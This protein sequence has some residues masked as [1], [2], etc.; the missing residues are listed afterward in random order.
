MVILVIASVEDVRKKEIAVWEIASCGVVS[1]AACISG[2]LHN[3]A[4]ALGIF[5]SLLPGIAILFIALM[6]GEGIGFGDGF[7]LLAAGPALGPFAAALGLLAA[8][9]AGSIF[10]GIL[11]LV[12]KAG[13]STRIP[14]VP[15]ITLGMGVM[16]LEKI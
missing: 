4:D 12:R 1:V 7:L 15:F 9:F 14:F 8:L 5:M 16:L 3:D 13:K 2:V 11:V 6:S 10:S